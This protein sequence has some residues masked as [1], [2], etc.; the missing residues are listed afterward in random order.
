MTTQ[1]IY[2][3]VHWVFMKSPIHYN[4]ITVVLKTWKN[5]VNLIFMLNQEFQQLPNII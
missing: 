3:C 1:F 4:T 2:N 5:E